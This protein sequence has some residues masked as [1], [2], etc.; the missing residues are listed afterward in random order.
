MERLLRKARPR[1]HAPWAHSLP[2]YQAWMGST[3]CVNLVGLDPRVHP[4]FA[5]K[6]I[7]KDMDC[8][9]KP[10]N[11]DQTQAGTARACSSDSRCPLEP[12]PEIPNRTNPCT[13]RSRAAAQACRPEETP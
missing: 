3:K 5:N 4:F 12:C 7:A 9:V 6:S 2:S 11:D 1:C 8:R 10:G 13:S